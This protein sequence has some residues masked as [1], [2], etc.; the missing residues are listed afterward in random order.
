MGSEVTQDRNIMMLVEKELK[1][2]G[3]FY[4]DSMTTGKSV[5]YKVAEE[6]GLPFNKR[7]VF[8]D[9]EQ[10]DAY[11][12]VQLELKRKAMKH[13]SAIAI[14]HPHPVTI[15]VLQREV[16]KLKDEGITL[17]RVSKFVQE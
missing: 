8:L 12:M 11:I 9:N 17:E 16:P 5:G 3:L 6:I 2:K 4:I 13:S 1:S 15:A 10:N 7:D 14:C